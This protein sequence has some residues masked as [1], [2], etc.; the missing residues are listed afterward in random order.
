MMDALLSL[1]IC[2]RFSY[3]IKH[4]LWSLTS[5]ATETSFPFLRS[6]N[7]N[8]HSKDLESCHVRRM[9]ETK[10]Q[11]GIGTFSFNK[12]N[13]EEK[14]NQQTK[15]AA[16]QNSADRQPHMVKI[17][18]HKW[19]KLLPKYDPQSET[20]INSCLWLGTISGQHRHTKPP[21]HTKTRVPTLVAPWPNQNI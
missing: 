7:T 21:R 18:Q 5:I 12:W 16:E 1:I 2:G 9:S 15:H 8:K 6:Y 10:A 20:T 13:T 11:H 19:G 14:L 3:K 4:W 17:P